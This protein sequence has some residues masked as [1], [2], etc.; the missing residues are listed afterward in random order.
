MLLQHLLP[1]PTP[2]VDKQ[3]SQLTLF[4]LVKRKLGAQREV[5]RSELPGDTRGRFCRPTR[6]DAALVDES[7]Y[8]T[9]Y[10]TKH[11]PIF[12]HEKPIVHLI[13]LRKPAYGRAHYYVHHPL[14]GLFNV[15]LGVSIRSLCPTF[16]HDDS[17][18]LARRGNPV[19]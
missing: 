14:R 15:F 5:L 19:P 2:G 12:R 13:Y 7:A 10:K 4:I 16:R 18:F 6:S 3:V 8:K 9:F 17:K 11:N 1:S